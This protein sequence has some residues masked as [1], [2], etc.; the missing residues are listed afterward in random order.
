MSVCPSDTTWRSNRVGLAVS[1][2]QLC[3]DVRCGRTG[4]LD[5]LAG[6]TCA[7]QYPSTWASVVAVLLLVQVGYY[8]PHALEDGDGQVL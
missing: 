2:A 4:Q 8:H 3:L 1:R 5:G 7:L 6:T